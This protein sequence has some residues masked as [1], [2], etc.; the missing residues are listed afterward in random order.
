MKFIETR[1]KI[2]APIS[3]KSLC[4]RYKGKL[5]KALWENNSIFYLFLKIYRTRK[6]TQWESADF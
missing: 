6:C 5:V 1:L 2:S 4:L 3:Q